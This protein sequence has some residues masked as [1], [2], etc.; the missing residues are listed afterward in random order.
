MRFEETVSGGEGETSQKKRMKA[1]K[2]QSAV[3]E[4]TVWIGKN[5]VTKALLDQITRQLEAN[6][7]IKVKVQKASLE[8]TKVAKL[9]GIIGRETGS[10]IVDVRGRTF[11]V[12]RQRK[13][14]QGQV[15]ADPA[16]VHRA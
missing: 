3:K 5:G 8:D 15:R 6:E 13:T 2:P 7:M 16:R 11:T 10:A 14:R 4:P 9:A 12:Y 1:L